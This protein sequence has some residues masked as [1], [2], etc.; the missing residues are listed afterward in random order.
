MTDVKA[1]AEFYAGIIGL[2]VVCS[3]D[4]N[5]KVTMGAVDPAAVWAQLRMDG[6]ELM[7]QT[8]ASMSEDL[9][10]CIKPTHRP[11]PFGSLYFRNLNPDTVVSRVQADRVA[12]GPSTTWYGMREVYLLDPDGYVVCVGQPEGPPPKLE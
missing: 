12:K 7:L 4:A 3:V 6:I 11:T 8:A 9:A 10:S 5:K 2:S 1:S